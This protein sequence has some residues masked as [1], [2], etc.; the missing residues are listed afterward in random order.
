MRRTLQYLVNALILDPYGT[1]ESMETLVNAYTANFPSH[2][3]DPSASTAA[4]Y[5]VHF[6]ETDLA[7]THT[8]DV[9][10]H[11]TRLGIIC[12]ALRTLTSKE[13]AAFVAAVID[14]VLSSPIDSTPSGNQ[15]REEAVAR[16][17]ERVERVVQH[18]PA[19]NAMPGS[20][21][22][23]FARDFFLLL[24]LFSSSLVSAVA[25]NSAGLKY[26]AEKPPETATRG[27]ESQWRDERHKSITRR[28]KALSSSDDPFRRQPKRCG[29][30][31]TGWNQLDRWQA[32]SAPLAA[33]KELQPR[34]RTGWATFKRDEE[35][36]VDDLVLPTSGEAFEGMQTNVVPQSALYA[37]THKMR[38]VLE[39]DERRRSTATPSPANPPEPPQVLKTLLATAYSPLTS[40][41]FAPQWL[42]VYSGRLAPLITR[43]AEAGTD[44]LYRLA[45]DF[46]PCILQQYIKHAPSKAASVFSK[47]LTEFRQTREKIGT[48]LPEE[49]LSTLAAG[50]REVV[51]RGMKEK[52]RI[53]EE[54]R[55]E[56]EKRKASGTGKGKGKEE[57]NRDP[58]AGTRAR[59]R[60]RR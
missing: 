7:W 47:R 22:S 24:S 40:I 28:L 10:R 21:P 36:K 43:L 18:V 13:R 8:M 45:I 42:S 35:G 39:D 6:R 33:A 32:M 44:N 5:L 49:E 41:T 57:T 50:L 55:K 20:P 1:L 31:K 23:A 16:L 51:A 11:P 46:T 30:S 37:M 27:W 9:Y 3:I 17:C 56:K 59:I 26:D 48:R 53:D 54:R 25:A 52:E 15:A 19:F 29:K 34:T 58:G 12:A 14:G 2:P 38:M 60:M 4:A